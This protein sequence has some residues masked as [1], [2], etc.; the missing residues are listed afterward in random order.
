MVAGAGFG[1]STALASWARNARPAWYTVD[2]RDRDALVLAR[3]LFHALRLRV[4]ALARDASLSGL[5]P[6]GPDGGADEAARGAAYAGQIAAAVGRA[7][8]DDV[9]LVVD[10][11]HELG[12]SRGAAG[13]IEGLFRQRPEQLRIVVSSRIEPPFPIERLRAQGRL[14]ELGP[15]DLRFAESE[16]VAMAAGMGTAAGEAS[17]RALVDKTGGWPAAVRLALDAGAGDVAGAPSDGRVGIDRTGETFDH[18]HAFLAEDVMP[19]LDPALR[20]LLDLVE[21]L[22]RFSVELVEAVGVEDAARRTHQLDRRGLFLKADPEPGWFTLQP[23]VRDFLRD[24]SA[25]DRRDRDASLPVAA[26]WLESDGRIEAAIESYRKVGAWSDV[27]RLLRDHGR[28]LLATGRASFVVDQCRGLPGAQR[29]HDVVEL[30]GEAH[31]VLGDWE[32]ALRCFD[33][34]DDGSD[35][36]EPSVAWRTGLIHHLRG[37]LD[38]AV[39]AYERGMA[40]VPAS[41]QDVHAA[42]V[43]AWG[44]A[45]RWLRGDLAGSEEAATRARAIAVECGD[46]AAA[47]AAHT[48]LAMVAASTGDRRANDAHYLRALDHAERAGDALQIIRIRSNRGSRCLEEGAYDDALHELDVALELADVSGFGS[49]RAMVLL[50]RGEVLLH[51]GRLEEAHRDLTAARAAFQAQGSRSVGY[52]LGILGDLHATRGDHAM[53]RT[54]YEEA[55]RLADDVGDLQGMVPSLIGL[56]RLLAA[57]EPAEARRFAERA[58]DHEAALSHQRAFLAA[59][60][61][62]RRDGD[63][64]AANDRIDAA[65]TRA[66]ARRDHQVIAEVLEFRAEATG[67][68]EAIAELLEARGIWET[69]QDPIGVTRVD[70]LLAARRRGAEGLDAAEAAVDKARRLGSRPLLDRATALVAELRHDATPAVVIETLGGFRVLRGGM[71]IPAGDWQS[72]KARDLVKILVTRRGQAVHREELIELLWPDDDGERGGSRLSVALST[73]RGVLDPDK[74]FDAE[75]I[76]EGDR[77]TLRLRPDEVAVDLERFLTASADAIAASTRDDPRA[78]DLLSRAEGCYGGEYLADDP[79]A[80]WA[81][82]LREQARTTY[83]D[84][85]RRLA[86]TRTAAGD[87]DGAARFLLRLLEHDPY[88]EGAHLDLVRAFSH[89]HR[90]GEARRAYRTYCARMEE[91]GVEPTPWEAPHRS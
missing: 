79:Y 81:V 39:G 64:A 49:L 58:V 1:K 41:D 66:R 74:R 35:V 21:P 62:A 86:A 90:H 26:A 13:L 51:L 43:L 16:V 85:V 23:L 48:A 22:D 60:I 9:V 2:E 52:A 31:H 46:H 67:D 17:A 83:L 18:V 82:P 56:A 20:E 24:R 32:S 50:N 19:G 69:L 61:A 40:A 11:L 68:A 76:I 57:S 71:A 59:A 84:V 88:D 80:D 78:P 36:L 87:S 29:D 47:A 34:L 37:D 6:R 27:A 72:R 53:A 10:D 28:G 55:L 75:A 91:I 42:L 30:E 45:A 8:S 12:E 38:L 15:D 7:S 25:G 73:A 89:A 4:P 33:S 5:T 63:E 3:G 65:E 77:T 54:S 14:L 44:A 70:L